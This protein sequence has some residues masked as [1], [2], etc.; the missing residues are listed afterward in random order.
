MYDNFIFS[1]GSALPIF[2]V[3]L[4]GYILK[5]RK[6]IDE[7]FISQANKMI[8]NVALPIKLFS[9]V[10]KTSFSEGFDWAFI[11]FIIIG[12]IISVL[13]SALV[14]FFAVKDPSKKGVFVQGAFRGNF[15]Y[16]G[17]S[18][19]ENVM[20]SIGAKAPL[21]IAFVI[22][23]YNILGVMVLSYYNT[24]EK[25]GMN[26]KSVLINILK[27]PLILSIGA[28]F[29]FSSAG[30]ELPEIAD[31]TFSYF[32]VLVTP[33]ALITIG[34]AFKFDKVRESLAISLMASLLK[35][36]IFPLIAV[37]IAINLG[38]NA[39]EVLVIYIVFGVPTAAVSYIM[40]IVMEGDPDLASGI[41]MLT[42]LL[43]N[44]TMTLFI[45]Y[46]RLIGIV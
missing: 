21:A 13:L 30:F 2:L 4:A 36:V 33:M 44:I 9:D 29:L 42:T 23:L 18:L 46:F 7:S 41:I 11:G 6:I 37:L 14:G 8:F 32:G 3:M 22:P 34:A 39:E 17:Y 16:V 15:L 35:L 38:F 43:S 19:L 25:N 5:Q 20:G 26:I 45:F 31:R 10:S 24:S 28:G 12:T 27:N 40:A 1:L